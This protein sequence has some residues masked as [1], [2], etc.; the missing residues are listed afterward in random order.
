[1]FGSELTFQ[2]R[3]A[4]TSRCWNKVV[5]LF[6]CFGLLPFFV[7]VYEQV[8]LLIYITLTLPPLLLRPVVYV[9]IALL[10]TSYRRLYNL[11]LPRTIP[12][13]LTF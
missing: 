3:I 8:L 13:L 7:L 10:Y 5:T 11:R 6:L 1:M 2:E 4:F 12:R 9:L